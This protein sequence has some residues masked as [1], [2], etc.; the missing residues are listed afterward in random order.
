MK[1]IKL[2]IELTYNDKFMHGNDKESIEWFYNDI[3]KSRKKNDLIL[4]SNDIGDE[5]GTVKVLTISS[6][7][8]EQGK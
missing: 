4:H 3:L 7:K 5:I 8:G 6:H 2:T 1:T